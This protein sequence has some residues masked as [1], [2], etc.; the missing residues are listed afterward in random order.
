MKRRTIDVHE[1]L[2][3]EIYTPTHALTGPTGY[4]DQSGSVFPMRGG[5]ST[6]GPAR[7]YP[8]GNSTQML[9]QTM[10]HIPYSGQYM[11]HAGQH[12]P[13]QQH[14]RTEMSH[15]EMNRP[16][17]VGLHGASDQYLVLDSYQKT[18]RS[19]PDMGEY[20]W[21]FMIQG[22]T[23]NQ[24]IGVRDAL[25]TVIELHVGDFTVPI[26]TPKEY[27]TNADDTVGYPP[28]LVSNQANP[29]V[30][31]PQL[32]YC[33]AMT[34]ELP[35]VGLQSISDNEGRRH[36]FELR[37]DMS[38]CG[39]RLLVTP[40][41]R[42]EIYIFTKPIKDIPG[43]S[44]IFRNPDNRISFPEDRYEGVKCFVAPGQLLSFTIPGNNLNPGEVVIIEDMSCANE[45]I[46]KWVNNPS[47]HL[48]G[49]GGFTAG[50]TFQLD[51]SVGVGVLGLSVGDE[52]PTSRSV[53]VMI[54]KNRIRIPLRVRRV[55]DDA[56]QY[57]VVG[58]FP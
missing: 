39:D 7:A 19:R 40:M 5:M 16:N 53:I 29:G 14:N 11:Q 18:P 49:I 56:T 1:E 9:H 58:N 33:G 20:N 8:R 34:M 17:P 46:N 10:S 26:P 13:T 38:D 36:H 28:I 35:E 51:P 37:T 43:L 32:P 31:V 3:R 47:G 30:T 24:A 2:K 55:I 48:V 12:T 27:V 52:I 57:H 42:F 54:P 44:V 22:S 21:N 25:D 6:N 15:F 45:N 23:G 50:Q 4:S 41:H